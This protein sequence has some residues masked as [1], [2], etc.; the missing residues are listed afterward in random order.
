LLSDIYSVAADNKTCILTL[1]ERTVQVR[2]SLR[3]LAQF[4]PAER[5]V[6]IQRSYFVNIA[7][8]ERLDPTRHL[9]QVGKQVL[10]VGRLYLA[11]LI[12][13]LRTLS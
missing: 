8:L 6:Q 5:F 9:V 7:H 11:E 12:S 2:L 4:L 1:S 3:E 13:R 10:P